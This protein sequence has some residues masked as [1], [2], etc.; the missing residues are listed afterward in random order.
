[1]APAL[2]QD[3]SF[4]DLFVPFTLY[5]PGGIACGVGSPGG[6]GQSLSGVWGSGFYADGGMAKAR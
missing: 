3:R 2:D 4:L 5:F 6:Q 1:M